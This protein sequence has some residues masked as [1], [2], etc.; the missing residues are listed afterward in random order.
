MR[1]ITNKVNDTKLNGKQ[2]FAQRLFLI[3]FQ[4][5]GVPSSSCG[6]FTIKKR[7]KLSDFHL[8][9]EATLRLSSNLIKLSRDRVQLIQSS[10][11][12]DSLAVI[13]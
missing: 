4:V 1:A 8:L 13:V 6:V 5:F 2:L 12:F 3:S 7:M 9:G 10:T 11:Q